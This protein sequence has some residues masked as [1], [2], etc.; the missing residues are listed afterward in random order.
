MKQVFSAY[1]NKSPATNN[2]DDIGL[3]QELSRREA[4]M[5][6]AYAGHLYGTSGASQRAEAQKQWETGCIRLES[7]VVDGLQRRSD[8]AALREA[9]ALLAETTGKVS[10]K[11]AASVAGSVMNTDLIARLN[12]MDPESPFVTQRPQSGYIWY[13]SG[14]GAVEVRDSGTALAQIE[15]GLSCA[16]FRSAEWLKDSRPEWPRALVA[17]VQKYAADVPQ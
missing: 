7:F 15:P 16:K 2:P 6:L 5:H 12:G 13:K 3:L 10:T 4:E 1:G 9:D 14:E 11:K 8:E 17:N